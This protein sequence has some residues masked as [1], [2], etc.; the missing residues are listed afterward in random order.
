MKK[1]IIF[2]TIALLLINVPALALEINNFGISGEASQEVI[3]SSQT[4][5]WRG[6]SQLDLEIDR[7]FGFDKYL[8]IN[9]KFNIKYDEINDFSDLKIEVD[10]AYFDLYLKNTDLRL[11]KQKVNWGTAYQYNPTDMVN[12]YDLTSENPLESQIGVSAVKSKYYI[13]PTTSLDG[14][15]VT[16]FNESPIP[17]TIKTNM[18]TEIKNRYANLLLSQGISP[19]NIKA[20]LNNNLF[21]NETEPKIES[22]SKMEYALNFTK[23]NVK[24]Y[25]LSVSYFNGYEDFPSIKSDIEAVG[26]K[27]IIIGNEYETFGSSNKTAELN[28]GYKKTQ[29]IG[30]NA[31]GSISK[32]GVW[33]EINYQINENDEQTTDVVLGSD[34]TFDKNL[35]TVAQ[36]I[37]R[38]YKDYIIKRNDMNYLLLHGDKPFRQIHQLNA[39]LIY[40]LDNNNY[41]LNPE[42]NLSLG[43]NLNLDIGATITDDSNTTSGYSVFNM[44]SKEQTYFKISY[45][46]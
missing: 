11:G 20:T 31:I 18:I 43:N 12:P 8:F 21:I 9:P 14:V 1:I 30:L 4:E 15:V 29:G 10:E 6:I 45:N 7:S 13:N 28:I 38:N 32:V 41:L 24:G 35:Y 40:D 37:H 42:I 17:D 39:N 2:L 5:S 33:S 19:I 16:D 27:L 44:I 25:D 26:E 34:Y 36:F 23:R 46:F 22:L 3:Y